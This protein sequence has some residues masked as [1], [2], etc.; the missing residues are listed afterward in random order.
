MATNS[1]IKYTYNGESAVKDDGFSLPTK[2][3]L[4]ADDLKGEVQLALNT[5]TIDTNGTYGPQTGYDGYSQVVV[6]VSTTD[7]VTWEQKTVT[8]S[9]SAQTIVPEGGAT[10]SYGLSQVTVNAITATYVGSGVPR[11]TST[12]TPTWGH[13]ATGDDVDVTV[14]VPAGYY[15]DATQFTYKAENILPATDPDAVASQILDGFQAYDEEGNLLEG[16]MPN[17][18]NGAVNIPAGDEYGKVVIPEGYY[19]GSGNAVAAAGTV[20]GDNVTAA[21]SGP[22]FATNKFTVTASGTTSVSAITAG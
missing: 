18:S 14:T 2:G 15:A 3:T 1:K 5:R 10:P 20:K 4:M 19:N 9:E 7:G 12:S 17:H 22:T 16:T 13:T 21:L 11:Q 6:N 8:P